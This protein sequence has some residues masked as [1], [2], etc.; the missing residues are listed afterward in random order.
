MSARVGPRRLWRLH[1]ITLIALVVALALTAVV[2]WFVSSL[3][4]TSESRLVKLRGR[5]AASALQ[6][7]LPGIETPIT[8][9]LAIARATGGS[10]SA[11][12]Q[13]IAPDV[14]SGD[15]FD[16]A[17][18]WRIG[19]GGPSLVTRVGRRSALAHRPVFE[20]TLFA[21]AQHIA[22]QLAVMG[23]LHPGPPRLAGAQAGTTPGGPT[24]LVYGEVA[25]PPARHFSLASSSPFADLDY[26][27]YLGRTT[28]SANLL[29]TNFAHLPIAQPRSVVA[30]PVGDTVLTLV[31]SVK[32]RLN[33]SFF[34]D[35]PWIIAIFG[36]LLAAAVAVTTE[37]LVRR[38]EAAERL[39]VRLD[40]VAAENEE[41]YREQRTIADTLQRA[42]LPERLP[43][44]PGA[45]LAARYVAGTKGVDVGGDWYD[46]VPLD[47]ERFAFA[48]GDV[49]GRGVRAA[50]IMASLRFAVRAYLLE[51][52]RPET[53][54]DKLAPLLDVATDEHFATLVV[55]LVGV[56]EHSL[57]LANAGHPRPVLLDDGHASS[58]D[59]PT[60]PPIGVSTA[61]RYA[62]VDLAVP[63][64]ATLLAFTDGLVERRREDPEVG[65]QR[66]IE[67]ARSSGGD[68]KPLA[69][70]LEGIISS[71][72]PEGA[73][74]D[75]AMLAVKWLT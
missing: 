5:D 4:N 59:L 48:V 19:P 27:L 29:V 15:L 16:T 67:V 21:R 23:V 68:G 40:V 60:G 32:G 62:S 69:P 17:S 55:G 28:A 1:P 72:A 6:A 43:A 8:S 26:A 47:N 41:L 74:D 52:H 25:I 31:T 2:S 39:A 12:D 9:G 75:I 30:I 61:T 38:R 13:Y 44:V 42:L 46:I 20:R 35:L 11:F 34:A 64:H 56:G 49:S 24:F 45:E 3:Y 10:A 18:L 54:L 37:H 66:L 36:V 63:P 14:G 50:S 58:L 57:R 71:L 53:V 22:P 7:A 51:G 73:D 33:S 65:R 70:L